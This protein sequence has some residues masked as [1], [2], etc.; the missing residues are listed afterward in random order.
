M[1]VE[2]N[3]RDQTAVGHEL[4]GVNLANKVF[5]FTTGKGSTGGAG[6]A[7]R[8]K[9]AGK[10]PAALICFN[11][12]PVMAAAILVADIPA[13]DKLDKNP[14]EVIETGDFVSVDATQG[15]VEVTKKS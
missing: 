10:A 1:C 7:Y 4:E 8:A 15:T 5:I 11:V 6:I 3:V 2:T 13:V 12:E 9:C 14:L